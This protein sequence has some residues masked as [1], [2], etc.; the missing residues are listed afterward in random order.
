MAASTT[1]RPKPAEAVHPAVN[2]AEVALAG[3]DLPLPVAVAFSGPEG[4][5]SAKSV[6]PD[7]VLCDIG[8]PGMDGFAVA[9][10]IRS[11]PDIRSCFLV[12]L[13][14][15]ASTDDIR[16]SID[17]GFDR[18]LAKPADLDALEATIAGV[19]RGQ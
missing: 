11:D 12:A 2:P 1:P 19:R 15:Y 7:V 17:A 18:H 4:L 16:R 3:L 14:G 6:R 9:R 13:S 10:A 8:L 5:A